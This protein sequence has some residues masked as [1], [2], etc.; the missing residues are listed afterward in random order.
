[1]LRVRSLLLKAAREFQ[2]GKTPTLAAHPGSTE[3]GVGR[4]CAGNSDWRV[5]ATA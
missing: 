5:L 3:G 1:M 4:W 2:A